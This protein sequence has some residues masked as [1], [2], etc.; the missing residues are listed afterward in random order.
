MIT[1]IIWTSYEIIRNYPNK[2]INEF[3][4]NNL[5]VLVQALTPINFSHLL[6]LP[7]H[8]DGTGY[9][10]AI[11]WYRNLSHYSFA[12]NIIPDLPIPISWYITICHL[13]VST[14]V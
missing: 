12:L 7:S 9:L 13:P 8:P 3:L 14:Q 6:D 11:H 4:Y 10:I 1:F 2:L 5:S